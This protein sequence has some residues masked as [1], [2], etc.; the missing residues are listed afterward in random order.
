MQHLIWPKPRAF[1][2]AYFRWWITL[3]F[4]MHWH[5]YKHGTPTEKS[6]HYNHMIWFVFVVQQ[7]EH[8]DLCEHSHQH[9][10]NVNFVP[11]CQFQQMY[12][13]DDPADKELRPFWVACRRS[14]FGW[15]SW[16]FG[17]ESWHVNEGLSCLQPWVLHLLICHHFKITLTGLIIRLFHF[18]H[19]AGL[20]MMWHI[21][22]VFFSSTFVWFRTVISM[23]NI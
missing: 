6:L 2:K 13:T 1:R 17:E 8:P 19:S 20:W 4:I 9:L 14:L 3:I 22:S 15:S 16:E 12:P 5:L 21:H 23:L 18:F 7:R 10:I 11:P